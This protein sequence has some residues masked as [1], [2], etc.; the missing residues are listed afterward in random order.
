VDKY[1]DRIG[2]I[3]QGRYKLVGFLGRGGMGA[4][5]LC[6]D[7]RLPGKRWALKEMVV[8]DPTMQDQ[9]EE[10]FKRE[11]AMLSR[12]RH[13]N[14]PMI[15]DYF[16]EG[17]C[18]YLVMEFISGETL[19][20]LIQREGPMEQAQSL[21]WA[22][23]LAQVLDYLHSQDNPIIFRDLKPE[24]VI[25]SEDRHIRLVD[26]GLARQFER[27]KLRDTQASGSVG[28]APPEQWEDSQQTDARSDIYSL[29]A[30]LFFILTARPPSPIYG[31]QRIRPYRPDLDTD[32]EAIVMKCL[33]PQP[34]DRYGKVGELIR[35][36]LLWLS[37]NAESQ[38]EIPADAPTRPEPQKF[39]IVKPV[40]TVFLTRVPR[41]RALRKLW[42]TLLVASFFYLVGLALGAPGYWASRPPPLALGSGIDGIWLATQPEKDHAKQ[43]IAAGNFTEAVAVLDQLLLKYPEDAEARILENNSYAPLQGKPLYHIPVICPLTGPDHEGRQMLPGLGLAQKEINAR[44]GVRGH[45]LALDLMDNECKL[46]RTIAIAQQLCKRVDCQIVLGPWTSQQVLAAAPLFESAGLPAVAPA[47]SDPRVWEAG[48]Y[49]LVTSDTDATRL[50][51]LAKYFSSAGFHNGVVLYNED[52][53]A[54]RSVDTQFI[55]L[56]SKTNGQILQ[57]LPYPEND[58]DFSGLVEKV[59]DLPADFVFVADFRA[60]AVIQLC[61]QLR[62]AGVRLPIGAEVSVFNPADIAEGGADLDGLLMATTLHPDSKDP[63]IHE[64]VRKFTDL[65]GKLTPSHRDSYCYDAMNVVAEAIEQVGFE[66]KKLDDYLSSLGETRPPAQGVTGPFS[67]GRRLDR[68]QAV[69]VQLKSGR[70][71]LLD[72]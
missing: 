25:I 49:I 13:R 57:N 10:S 55:D 26:F 40:P 19:A 68:R 43:L 61:H 66:R 37:K 50:E 52:D 45:L 14:L 67:P 31:S 35:D 12:L 71:T 46:D 34:S 56:F 38:G 22:L 41:E 32:I 62:R 33:Q 7:L 6:D 28:Y 15:I 1:Q 18:Q 21:R 23:E 16:I 3:F 24:N 39:G 47:A 44:G 9:V 69:V 4:V 5:Y 48:R 60:H 30:T 54:S 59:K 11:A 8:Y 53:L 42:P 17:R 63:K 70:Y 64:F 27:S 29:G 2:S 36:L 72:N 58:V 51:A 20:R 65:Y